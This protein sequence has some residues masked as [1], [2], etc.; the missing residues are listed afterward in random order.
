MDPSSLSCVHIGLLEIAILGLFI[1]IAGVMQ[2]VS[3]VV[4]GWRLP[5]GVQ[6]YQAAIASGMPVK[7]AKTAAFYAMFGH[8]G[9]RWAGKQPTGKGKNGNR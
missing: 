5:L 8:T 2:F 7:A 4:V 3:G 1:S 9:I 6:A